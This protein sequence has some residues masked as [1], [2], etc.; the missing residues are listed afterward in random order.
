MENNADFAS[1]LPQ[2][3]RPENPSKA[4]IGVGVCHM[5]STPCSGKSRMLQY[6]GDAGN[7]KS[8]SKRGSGGGSTSRAH[9]DL[10]VG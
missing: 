5:F 8:V 10:G 4:G 9:V 1:F 2:I 6:S 3:F 7:W